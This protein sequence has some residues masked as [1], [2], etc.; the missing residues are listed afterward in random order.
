MGRIIIVAALVS[1]LPV[2]S[3]VSCAPP[4][5]RISSFQAMP[6]S[7]SAGQAA[8]LKWD[9]MGARSV[10]LDNGLGEQPASGSIEV[11]PVQTTTYRLLAKDGGRSVEASLTLTVNVPP[12]TPE[13]EQIQTFSPLDT[14]ALTGHIGERVRVEG[15]VTY[16]SSWLPTR[17]RGFGTSQPW[18]F[19]FFMKDVQEGAA[20]NAGTGEYCPECWRDYTSQFRVI[21]TPDR[22]ASLLPGL[23]RCFGGGLVL[24]EQ[25]LIVG[26][27]NG[28][29]IYVPSQLWSY[30]YIAKTPVRIAIEGEL[31]NYL[32]APAIYLTQPSQ[33]S[34]SQP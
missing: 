20:D 24:Q 1:I 5:I 27:V 32:L 33:L 6:S 19:M 10:T 23:N 30:G 16:I 25:W 18:T 8:L 21:I 34:C 12:A 15:D 17:F 11:R 4:D 9:V 7:I 2:L 13:K 31:T 28:R 29:L 22:L 3:I 26:A 14:Q